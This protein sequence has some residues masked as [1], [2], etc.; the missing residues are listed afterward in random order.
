MAAKIFFGVYESAEIRMTK[1]FLTAIDVVELGGSIGVN[2]C[3][4]ATRAARVITVE[5]DPALCDH[6]NLT[7]SSNG[8]AATVINAAIDYTGKPVKFTRRTSTLNGRVGTTGIDVPAKTLHDILVEYRVGPYALVSDIEGAEVGI[9]LNDADAL[10][11]CVLVLIE[12][13]GAYL[14]QEYGPDEVAEMF[15]ARGFSQIYRYG[16]CAAFV[17]R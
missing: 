17:R 2:T 5:A 6:L 14:G 8:L 3:H 1:R 11:S 10:E 7:L 16:H 13:G 15:D 12:M 4:I 9:L